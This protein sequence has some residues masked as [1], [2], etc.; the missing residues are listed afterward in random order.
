MKCCNVTFNNVLKM[1][2]GLICTLDTKRQSFLTLLCFTCW[3]LNRYL[4][5]RSGL[6]FETEP[7][8]LQKDKAFLLETTCYLLDTD[9]NCNLA[10]LLHC[11]INAFVYFNAFHYTRK[12]QMIL[13]IHTKVTRS[14][15]HMILPSLPFKFVF[16]LHDWLDFLPTGKVSEVISLLPRLAVI[17]Q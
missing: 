8:F 11:I 17:R 5:Y 6:S 10:L 3:E 7:I 12:Y 9:L 16:T 13:L 4:I 1:C 2:I 14:V 15:F